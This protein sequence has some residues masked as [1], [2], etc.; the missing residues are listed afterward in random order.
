MPSSGEARNYILV[1]GRGAWLSKEIYFIL[2]YLSI[3]LKYIIFNY[4]KPNFIILNS[5]NIT[6]ADHCFIL[7]P[8]ST[9]RP[10]YVFPNLHD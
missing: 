10:Y 2:T 6:E 7:A 1:K 4:F 5:L 9:W 3:I 8:I